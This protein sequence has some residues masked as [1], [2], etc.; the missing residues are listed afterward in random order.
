MTTA[1][2]EG[3]G[4]RITK[5]LFPSPTT[6]SKVDNENSPRLVRQPELVVD[7]LA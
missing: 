3:G 4:G 1:T 2:V 6:M 7:N 5:E